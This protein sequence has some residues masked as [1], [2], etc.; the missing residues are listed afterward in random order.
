MSP[1]TN[2]TGKQTEQT[3]APSVAGEVKPYVISPENAERIYAFIAAAD[4]GVLKGGMPSPS[5]I[6]QAVMAVLPTV[7]DDQVDLIE[8]QVCVSS[9]S[10][11]FPVIRHHTLSHHVLPCTILQI[12]YY[13]QQLAYKQ[14]LAEHEARQQQQ[15]ERERQ[16]ASEKTAGKARQ[17]L[18]QQKQKQLEDEL[19]QKAAEVN[20]IVVSCRSY[21]HM[22]F[23]TSIFHPSTP[24]IYH[25]ITLTSTAR[26]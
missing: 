15:L 10:H 2:V 16:L 9:I 13:Y 11:H 22:Y 4:P 7:D 23:S 5:T 1:A 25:L 17:L 8:Q 20:Q 26:S 12:T 18:Q 6:A 3:K 24:L 14:Q 19:K 21:L